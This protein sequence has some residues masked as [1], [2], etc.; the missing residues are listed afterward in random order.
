MSQHSWIQD[1]VEYFD[2]HLDEYL[3]LFY[4]GPD[5]KAYRAVADKLI[6][7]FPLNS[8]LDLGSGPSPSLPALYERVKNYV[9]IEPS[10]ANVEH[11]KNHFPRAQVFQAT[12]EDL[13]RLNCGPFDLI[14][15]FGLLHHI[16]D[17]HLVVRLC[18][19]KLRKKG[20]FL[21]HEPSDYWNG[22]M[23][24]P[25]ERGFEHRKLTE[26]ISSQFQILQFR[27]YHHPGLHRALYGS[28]STLKLLRVYYSMHLWHSLIGVEHVLDVL[29]V[30]GSD[31]LVLGRLL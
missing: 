27:S 11:L 23:G 13:P 26:L 29:G 5:W 1:E 14:V 15:S 3:N 22:K 19:N 25:N 10:S 20:L 8:V 16:C 12:A 31:F 18:A 28:L 30:R 4:E 9:C 2:T 24:S 6:Q 21:A 7:H 17:P